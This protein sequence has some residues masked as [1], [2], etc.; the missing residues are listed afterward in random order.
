M[1]MEK[2]KALL[3]DDDPI[4]L[5]LL[6]RDLHD[7]CS[8]QN[9]N[10]FEEAKSLLEA[11][12]FDIC[13]FDLDLDLRSAGLELVKLARQKNIYNVMISSHEDQQAIINAYQV[14]CNDYLIKPANKKSINQ[15]FEKYINQ[16]S[17]FIVEDLISRHY[18]TKDS[19]T[20]AQLS[21]LKKITLSDKS[22][23]I[24]GESGT[25][26]MVVARMIQE[27]LKPEVFFSINC[28]SLNESTLMSELFGHVKGAFTGANENKTGLFEAA[29]GGLLFL[30]E[31]HL[32]SARAQQA[33]LTF[34]EDGIIKPVGS[35]KLKKVNVR[36]ICAAREYLPTLIEKGEFR[37][38]IYYR[39]QS[40]QINLIPLRFRRADIPAQIQFFIKKKFTKARPLIITDSAMMKLCE[41]EWN[42]G[43]T[44]EIEALVDSWYLNSMGVIDTINLPIHIAGTTQ[45]NIELTK[46]QIESLKLDGYEN[47]LKHMGDLAKE[48]ALE[49]SS[50]LTSAAKLLGVSKGTLSKF[51]K[52]R[53]ENGH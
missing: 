28:A 47:F 23:L 26:K 33:L 24:T 19:N 22:I 14:G 53:Q 38:D 21:L 25:G 8:I 3:V 11:N 40:L 37:D 48:Y 4:W 42:N 20:L 32:L 50:N 30:D 18:I 29:N 36:L 39:L 45:A 27:I 16:R 7:F 52:Q 44:R 5:E 12:H 15:I 6:S 46:A 2:F 9:A 1:L 51:N 34:L 13:F 35:D 10:T 43:N 31:V 49:N 41:Y 17:Q